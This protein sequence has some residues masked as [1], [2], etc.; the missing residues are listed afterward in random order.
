[1]NGSW[2]KEQVSISPSRSFFPRGPGSWQEVRL[3]MRRKDKSL[4]WSRNPRQRC[5]WTKWAFTCMRSRSGSSCPWVNLSLAGVGGTAEI[6]TLNG[7]VALSA[8]DRQTHTAPALAP[9][10]NCVLTAAPEVLWY[11]EPSASNSSYYQS[12]PPHPHLPK[13]PLPPN[14]LFLLFPWIHLYSTLSVSSQMAK[15]I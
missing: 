2:K 8:R 1:M 6:Q 10:P 4:L 3:T 12:S 13:S 15:L 11:F 7:R 14:F 9:T 5:L